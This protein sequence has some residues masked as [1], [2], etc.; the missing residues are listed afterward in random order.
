MKSDIILDGD[1][2]EL[3]GSILKTNI[4]DINISCNSEKFF[5]NEGNISI[6]SNVEDV[7]IS[8]KKVSLTANVVDIG[9]YSVTNNQFTGISFSQSS[10]NLY[11]S[12]SI[13]NRNAQLPDNKQRYAI[14]HSEYD[15]LFI[16]PSGNYTGGVKIDGTVK[17]SS[18]ISVKKTLKMDVDSKL[19]LLMPPKKIT[20]PN[21]QTKSIPV[22]PIDVLQFIKDLQ[23]KING[24][25]SRVAAFEAIHPHP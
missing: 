9:S 17:I 7:E 8:G 4:N 18:D 2:I 20:L 24:L 11:N 13:W 19:M 15:E 1:D 14:M 5:A 10:V 12:I 16:N 23:A 3:I 21:G 22:D 25:E 6:K